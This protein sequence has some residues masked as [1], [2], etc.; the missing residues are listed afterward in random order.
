IVVSPWIASHL[1]VTSDSP[2]T[3]Q[4]ALPDAYKLS[5]KDW[6]IIEDDEAAEVNNLSLQYPYPCW[7]RVKRGKYR[8]AVGYLFDSEQ[9][10]NFVTV[11]IPPRDFPYDMPKGSV[12]LFDPS[13]LPPGISTTD[14]TRNGEIVGEKYKGEEY[15][16]GLLKKTFHRYSTELVHIPHPNDIRLH[17]QAGWDLPF[18]R[19]AE[20]A[21]SKL[22][23]RAGD[24]VRLHT[25]DLSGQLCTTEAALVDVERVFNVGDEVRVIAGVYQGVAGHL[26]Q[27]YEDNFTICQS[28]T[29]QEVCHFDFLLTFTHNFPDRSFQVLLGS[30]PSGSHSTGVHVGPS[31]RRPSRRAQVHR[32]R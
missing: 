26:V 11:L 13:R 27:K 6:D 19:K 16:C 18:T 32:N 8:D 12:A 14:V 30:S 28:G 3:I 24:T 1:Y 7:L 4:N 25:P 31:I 23:L 29:Q 22:S 17:H 15:Y 21:F 20:V 2:R 9:S 5:I 10:N